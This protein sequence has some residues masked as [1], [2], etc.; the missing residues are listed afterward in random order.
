MKKIG[1]YPGC[2][3]TGTAR[4][5]K[6][7][8]FLVAKAADI[9]LCEIQDWSCCGASSA[10]S[11]NRELAVALPARNLALAIHAGFDEIVVP[12]AACYSRLI[13]AQHQ[14]E[15]EE[16]SRFQIEEEFSV[17]FNSGLK[18]L[19]V[20][21]FLNKHITPILSQ[22]VK[23]P[24]NHTYACY[25]GCL[26]VRPSQVVNAERWEDPMML[27]K[28]I[29]LTGGCA[30]DW[31]MKTEC[32]GASFSI[33]KPAIVGE[34]SGKIVRNAS[35]MGAEA[36]VVACPMC[37][38]NLDMRRPEI[39]SYLNRKVDIPVLYITQVIALSL[40]FTREQV[41]LDRH[42]VPVKLATNK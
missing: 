19:S 33:S 13:L 22:L 16:S 39:N 27:E 42:F 37:H 32:C 7:S 2:S 24:M 23:Q 8:L 26:L 4:E 11:L 28:I 3:L 41:G 18:I 35:N 6:D 20:I 21:D 17:R 12:C 14:I 10:H 34:L 31:P 15:H 38:S 30:I 25:Y 5:Y 36:L 1:F 9:E 29:E 40:G